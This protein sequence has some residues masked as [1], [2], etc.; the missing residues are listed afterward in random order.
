MRDWAGAAA[1]TAGRL[2]DRGLQAVADGT[3][4]LRRVRPRRRRGG[5]RRARRRSAALLDSLPDDQLAARLDAP[6]YLGFAEYFC[7]RFDDAIRHLRRGIDGLARD[8]GQ[9]QFVIP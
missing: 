3:A 7:E 2:G 1:E 5:R 8:R 6:Y 9:G 4:V